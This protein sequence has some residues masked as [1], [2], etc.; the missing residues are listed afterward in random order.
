MAMMRNLK[1]AE[2]ARR[3][4]RNVVWHDCFGK[5]A[6]LAFYFQLALFPLLIFVLSL[7]SFMSGAEEIIISWLGTLMPADS[8]KMIDK[9]V[10]SVLGGRSGGLLSFSLIFSLWSSSQGVRALLVALNR[11]YDI[12]EGRPF[13]KSQLLAL[14][15]TMALCLLIIGGVILI[16]FGDPL[17]ESLGSFLGIEQRAGSVWAVLHYTTGLA[18]LVVG[19]GSVYYFGPNVKQNVWRIA[20]GTFFA[21]IAF[22][23]VSYLF[24]LYLRYAPSYYAVYGSLGAVIILMLWLYLMA[25]IM[26]L[27]GEINAE[28][29]KLAGEPVDR[30][31]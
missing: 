14:G 1:L 3:I 4:S 28:V 15:I 22:I 23:V 25:F 26:Y 18:M 17:L 19:M 27:G 31:E 9:W 29:Q 21:V 11:A 12:E 5:A 20:P 6:E 8:T 16:T 7:I 24:S 2:L 30:K 13:W 10:H